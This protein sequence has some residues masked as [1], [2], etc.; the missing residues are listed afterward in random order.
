ML[1]FYTS[2]REPYQ[3]NEWLNN[4]HFLTLECSFETNVNIIT[5]IF[6]FCLSLFNIWSNEKDGK[7]IITI[8]RWVKDVNNRG[9][10]IHKKQ[11]KKTFVDGYDFVYCPEVDSGVFLVSYNGHMQW[12]GIFLLLEYIANDLKIGNSSKHGQK[13]V[14]SRVEKSVNMPYVPELDGMAADI[15]FNPHGFPSRM[16]EG[17]KLELALGLLCAKKGMLG[18]GT[19]FEYFFH[20]DLYEQLLKEELD[21]FSY[22]WVY[23]GVTGERYPQKMFC[24]FISYMVLKHMSKLKIHARS[25]GPVNPI[26]K[27]PTPGL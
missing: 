21:K 10:F 19:S 11:I 20:E 1:A 8:K 18:D 26:T 5:G 22:Y 16:T 4:E 12:T 24:G 9:R 17:Q 25:K 13:A 6:T 14:I 23:D 3:T 27:Q 2:N 15:V 7:Y